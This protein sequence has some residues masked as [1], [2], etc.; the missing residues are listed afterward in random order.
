M[1]SSA[2]ASSF[3]RLALPWIACLFCAC[4][5]GSGT[6]TAQGVVSAPDC[7]LDAEAFDLEPNFFAI[8]PTDDFA[9]ITIQHGSALIDRSD[10]LLIFINDTET[11]ATTRLGEPIAVDFDATDGVSMSLA[12]NDTCHIDDA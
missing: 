3:E 7:G 9:E 2:A 4:S 8:D 1:T 5:V 11:L 6:G 12:L 10:A